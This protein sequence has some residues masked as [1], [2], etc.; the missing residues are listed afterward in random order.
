V[1]RKIGRAGTVLAAAGFVLSTGLVS[2]PASAQVATKGQP[3]TVVYESQLSGSAANTGVADPSAVSA[4]KAAFA[5]MPVTIDVCD[6]Q[7]TTA[8]NIDCEHTAVADHA[9]AFVVTQANQDQSVVDQANVPVIGV[10]NDTSPQSFDIS[11]QQG[12]F[13]GMAVALQKKGCKRI[14]QVID[15][16]GQAYGAQVANAVKWQSVTDSY[17][18]LTAPDLTPY[19]AKLVQA[20]VQCLDMAMISTQI[21]QALTAVKQANLKVPIAFPGVIL[22]PAVVSSLGTLGNGLI[23]VVSTPPVNSPASAAVAKKMHAVN[24]NINVENTSLDSWASARVIQDGAAGVHG[25]VTNTSLLTALNKLRGASTDGL[26]PPLNMK[27]QANPAA[28]RDFDT[29]VETVVLEHGQQTAPS[30]FFDVGP[31]INTAL[32]NG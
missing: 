9:A 15:E 5:G 7:G 6:D 8:G 23:E 12:L 2:A 14:G 13:V 29:Y 1:S 18:S 31:E 24:K 27:P 17:I 3:Y 28:L 22:T 30:G 21:P 16:G 10:A 19:I 25:T 11:A 4:F 32:T 20:R 26:L